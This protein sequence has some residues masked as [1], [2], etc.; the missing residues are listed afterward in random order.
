MFC[1]LVMRAAAAA[2]GGG[3]GMMKDEDAKQTLS[4]AS[5]FIVTGPCAVGSGC[6]DSQY[7]TV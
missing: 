4:V 5:S 1:D 2:G 7:I 6:P 3:G